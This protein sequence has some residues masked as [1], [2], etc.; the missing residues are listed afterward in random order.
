MLSAVQT[1]AGHQR[2]LPYGYA[3]VMLIERRAGYGCGDAVGN[4]VRVADV[5][6][7]GFKAGGAVQ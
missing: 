2:N 7:A 3:V 6:E 5:G 1:D 4:P